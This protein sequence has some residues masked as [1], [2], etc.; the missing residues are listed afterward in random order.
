[1]SNAHQANKQHTL[2]LLHLTLSAY[3]YIV[4]GMEWRNAHGMDAEPLDVGADK[5]VVYAIKK[6][7]EAVEAD[8]VENI[9]LW[10]DRAK[11]AIDNSLI[12]A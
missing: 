9:L 10:K 7:I 2:R 4:D 8:D 1:M 3:E 5:V 12:R 6:L 11:D